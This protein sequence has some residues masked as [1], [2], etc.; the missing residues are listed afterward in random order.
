MGGVGFGRGDADFGTGLRIEDAV[1]FA[2]HAGAY[3]ID[4]RKDLCAF[5]PRDSNSFQ[6]VGRFPR[7]RDGYYDRTFGNDGV[8]IAKFGGGVHFHGNSCEGFD[9]PFTDQAGVPGGAASDDEHLCA[10]AEVFVHEDAIQFDVP[11]SGGNAIFEGGAQNFRLLVDLFEHEVGVAVFF[12]VGLLP[13]DGFDVEVLFFATDVFHPHA[14]PPYFA[15]LPVIE[16]EHTARVFDDGRNI[17]RD[18]IFP[19]AYS[20]DEGTA[21]TGGDED[22]GAV[23]GYDAKGVS[24]FKA[25]HGLPNGVE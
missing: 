20:D 4:N 7:L 15:Y 14:I 1:G 12:G 5:V 17:G 6:G 9:K 3:G 16:V 10:C 21:A 24:A 25:A 18:I 2:G 19:I 11:R 8:A 13:L 23:L 22:I